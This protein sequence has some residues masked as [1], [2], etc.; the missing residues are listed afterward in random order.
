M[1]CLVLEQPEKHKMGEVRKYKQ[2]AWYGKIK[3]VTPTTS[4]ATTIDRALEVRRYSSADRRDFCRMWD[5]KIENFVSIAR[6]QNKHA[7]DKV[8]WFGDC[9]LNPHAVHN[10]HL[11]HK[12]CAAW[13]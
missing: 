9:S 8:S 4:L 6:G 10:R 7:N 5:K 1:E 11:V 13:L 12:Y 2:L 3:L